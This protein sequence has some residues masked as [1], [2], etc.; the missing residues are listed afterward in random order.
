M[1]FKNYSFILL[2]LIYLS[3][4]RGS[5]QNNLLIKFNDG[6]SSST[7]LNN[8]NKITFSN[9]NLVLRSNDATLGMYTV[10]SIRNIIFNNTTGF[11]IIN[12]DEDKI[13]IYLSD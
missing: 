7:S 5:A 1:K 3:I 12:R 9:D 8:I 10:T 6:T 11:E 4:L 13:V 2:G